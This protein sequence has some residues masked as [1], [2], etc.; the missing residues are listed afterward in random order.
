MGSDAFLVID[1]ENDR[2][3][4]SHFQELGCHSFKTHFV[5]ST[6]PLTF[7]QLKQFI[8]LFVEV[9]PH[10]DHTL[11]PFILGMQFIQNDD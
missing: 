5:F 4:N 8:A 3:A 6:R 9:I 1:L 7:S 2:I 11:P 10:L